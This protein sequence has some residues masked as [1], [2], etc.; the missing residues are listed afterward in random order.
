MQ[1][2]RYT[3]LLVSNLLKLFFFLRLL[4]C[5]LS[6]TQELNFQNAYAL[7]SALTEE[8]SVGSVSERSS[9]GVGSL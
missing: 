6:L 1:L 5:P 8:R 7:V 2:L 9:D 3:F 4:S